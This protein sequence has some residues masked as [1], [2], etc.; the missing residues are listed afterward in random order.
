MTKKGTLESPLRPLV[1]DSPNQTVDAF[2]SP[3]TEQEGSA[4]TA[5]EGSPSVLVETPLT[6]ESVRIDNDS[7]E[8]TVENHE[9]TPGVQSTVLEGVE[10][11]APRSQERE[12]DSVK[13]SSSTESSAEVGDLL[14]TDDEEEADGSRKC[15]PPSIR[16]ESEREFT[17]PAS[18]ASSTEQ[19]S[20]ESS[21]GRALD[22]GRI[23][24]KKRQRDNR[25]EF[26]RARDERKRTRDHASI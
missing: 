15:D 19:P 25:E 1:A 13:G 26:H 22:E 5:T 16:I 7:E 17:S 12:V 2:C 6:H 8:E 23:E 14:E 4:G 21:Y 9:S 18:A 24:E 3:T 11:E 20:P 10:E